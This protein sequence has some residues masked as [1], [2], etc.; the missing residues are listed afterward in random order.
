MPCDDPY[1][2]YAQRKALYFLSGKNPY[3]LEKEEIT[4]EEAGR[5]FAQF[6]GVKKVEKSNISVPNDIY[7][8]TRLAAE[9]LS[10]ALGKQEKHVAWHGLDW[11][12]KSAV[13]QE[14]GEA[15]YKPKPGQ[16]AEYQYGTGVRKVECSDSL[17]KLRDWLKE[18][19]PDERKASQDYADAAVK[20]N[21]HQLSTF[22]AALNSMSNDEMEHKLIIEIIVDVIT[23]RCDGGRK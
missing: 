1:I 7:L 21:Y 4:K 8:G 3:W 22:N 5:A 11:K 9:K 20:M 14:Q 13:L 10:K 16:T 23:E 12:D 19:I 18:Q 6:K 2:S 15:L 17:L